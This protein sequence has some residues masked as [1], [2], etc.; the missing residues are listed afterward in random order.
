MASFEQHFL[1][2]AESIGNAFG[3]IFSGSQDGVGEK[4]CGIILSFLG[5]SEETVKNLDLTEPI[6]LSDWRVP[7]SA[8]YS[9]NISKENLIVPR[10][11]SS[12]FLDT[13]FNM[14]NKFILSFVII[15]SK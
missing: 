7:E 8:Y 2:T 15:D 14:T 11:D 13:L 10:T 9:N 5:V 1:D 3:G 6:N 12:T 4:T